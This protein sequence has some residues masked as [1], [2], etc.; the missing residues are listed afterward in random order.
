[1]YLLLE[2]FFKPEK[3]TNYIGLQNMYITCTT[4]RRKEKHRFTFLDDK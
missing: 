3:Y 2:L 4:Y 1:M